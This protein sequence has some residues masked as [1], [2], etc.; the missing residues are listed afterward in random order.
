MVPTNLEAV[1][2]GNLIVDVVRLNCCLHSR[3]WQ[4]LVQCLAW[5]E[6]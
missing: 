4:L 1:T 2:S 3:T 6:A 5:V